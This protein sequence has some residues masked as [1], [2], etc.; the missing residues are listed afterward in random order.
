MSSALV[1]LITLIIG[2]FLG[3]VL[4]F[5]LASRRSGNISDLTF[6]LTTAR[7]ERDLYKS[8][9]DNAVD[10]SNL[11]TQIES[12]KSAMEKLQK[13]A[14]EA[15]RRRIDAESDIRTQVRTMST[16][17]E[18]LV[19]QTKAIAGALSHSQKRGKFGEAQLELMLEDAGLHK[20]IEYSAQRST[21]DSDSSGI[22]DITVKM[23]GG[24]KLFIDSKFPF[25]RFIEAHEVEDS[26][27]REQL[28]IEHKKDLFNHVVALSKRGYQ[29]SQDSP[30]FVILFVPFES[31]L[32]EALRVDP[33]FLE[34][35]FKL[36]V[37][38][39]TPTSMMALLRT[40]GNVYSRNAVAHN[41]EN[42]AQSAAVFMKDLTLLHTKII[43]VGT[44]INSL[45]KAYG[46][47]IPTAE[48]T[49]KRAAA[50][51]LSFGVSADKDKL[52]LSYPDAPAPVRELKNGELAAEDD[53]IDA[54]EI[55]DET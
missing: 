27:E 53:F 26:D 43:K 7:A 50:K 42:I 13:E 23:P 55:E 20:G 21:T 3:T 5:L 9:R 28:F 47:L 11:A 15:D 1:T 2:L 46:D 35:A 40:I 4:G 30:D 49:V 34:N 10:D 18:S 33:L 6:Q 38:I 17:N 14:Q 19:A 39:A 16:H 29:D 41:A 12:M 54:E 36:N 48:S 22:P 31:L 37:T 32:T 25:D 24:T 52:A 44:A 51:I 8:E 45:S